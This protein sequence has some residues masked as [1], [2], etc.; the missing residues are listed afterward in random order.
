MQNQYY[1]N[2]FTDMQTKAIFCR[3][4]TSYNTGVPFNVSC[5]CNFGPDTLR[6]ETAGQDCM[7]FCNIV[8]WQI[9]DLLYFL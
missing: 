5:L 4:N 1:F 7:G 6:A 8:G 3:C 2:I 9:T